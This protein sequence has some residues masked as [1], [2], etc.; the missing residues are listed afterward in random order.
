MRPSFSISMVLATTVVGFQS[1]ANNIDTTHS[2]IDP[3][4]V[5]KNVAAPKAIIG[6]A[7]KFS[8]CRLSLL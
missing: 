8:L 2:I 3:L 1:Y 5:T 7:N 4:A 6:V